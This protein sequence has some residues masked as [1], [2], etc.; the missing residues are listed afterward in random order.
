[1]RRA[2]APALYEL[3]DRIA[4]TVGVRRLD[5]VQVGTEFTVRAS[6][7]GIRRRLKLEVGLPLW[8][9]L[10]PQERVAV[11]ARTGASHLR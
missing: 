8:L 11:A 2:D 7:Y 4:D 9:T 3:L 1:M 10:T 6:T 5:A